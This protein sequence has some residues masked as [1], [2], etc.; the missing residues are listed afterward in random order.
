LHITHAS[1]IHA[2]IAPTTLSE[3]ISAR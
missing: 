2:I 1:K 3:T